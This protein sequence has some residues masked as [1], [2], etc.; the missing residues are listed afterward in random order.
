MLSM[1]AAM[2]KMSPSDGKAIVWTIIM[3]YLLFFFICILLL[4]NLFF[5]ILSF[6]LYLLN[7]RGKKAV[8]TVAAT[9]PAQTVVY[10]RSP[11]AL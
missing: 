2:T 1:R 7:N 3:A 5:N 9:K 6:R 4:T 11:V 8:A 10:R